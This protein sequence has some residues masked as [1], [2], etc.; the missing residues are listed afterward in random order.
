[1]A[2]AVTSY[3]R[4]DKSTNVRPI[5]TSQKM[6]Q[7]G[8]SIVARIT[9][10]VNEIS[11]TDWR[12][13]MRKHL[14]MGETTI[15]RAGAPHGTK[16]AARVDFGFSWFWTYGHLLPAA[17]LTTAAI[18]SA[19]TGGPG[20]LTVGLGVIAIWAFAGFLV[21]RFVVRMNELGPLPSP[22]FAT[23]TAHVLDLGCGSGR[24]SIIV[25]Q[26]RPESRITALDDFSADYIDGHGEANTRA[27]FLAAGV[28]DRVEI[29]S[30]DMRRLPFPDAS[31]DGVVSSAAIDHLERGDI[32][33]TLAEVNR[34]LRENGQVLLWLIVP[35]LWNLIATGPLAYL[36][37]SSLR[38]P[39][40]R[41]MLGTAGFRIDAE[42]TARGLAWIQATRAREA[43]VPV[44]ADPA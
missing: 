20:W 27:D 1:M 28:A 5:P 35:N 9:Q 11:T 37:G 32:P 40:W 43:A 25:A 21:T 16:G 4:Q 22:D 18:A 6:A 34:V 26:A 36:H 15:E 29:R 44:A 33:I 10:F 3:P 8:F 31:F 2:Q 42:G 41:E 39:V 19:Q 7:L 30:G 23:G 12:I 17:A 13:P 24:T 38:T 14:E